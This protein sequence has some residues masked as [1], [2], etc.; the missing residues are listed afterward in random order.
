MENAG[1]VNISVLMFTSPAFV[2]E[3]NAEVSWRSDVFSA[4]CDSSTEKTHD[5]LIL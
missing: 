3:S 4:V 2:L 1:D 5:M